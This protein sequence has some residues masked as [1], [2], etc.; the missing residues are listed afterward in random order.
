MSDLTE[1]QEKQHEIEATIKALL[2]LFDA[3][4]TGLP[5]R[6]CAVYLAAKKEI[7]SAEIDS[8]YF[9]C[10]HCG[11]PMKDEDQEM[12]PTCRILSAIDS[13]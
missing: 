9:S 3:G 2:D 8:A 7:L 12:H 13:A 1:M 6:E 10:S 4:E 5:V 11:E